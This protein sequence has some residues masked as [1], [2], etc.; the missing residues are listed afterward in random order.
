M[1]P[2]AQS[3]A[4]AAYS[5]ISAHGGVA[6]ADPRRLIQML[7]DGALERIAHARGHLEHRQF[8]EK[9]RLLHAAVTI[10][11]E[12]RASLDLRAGGVIAANLDDLY[13]YMCR[14]LIAANLENRIATLDEVSHLLGL[15]RSAWVAMPA[16]IHAAPTG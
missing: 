2:A 7:M 15:I 6:A 10:I 3:R 5:S 1:P 11:G 9:N 12:L 8:A 13:D 4:S 16:E 14:Q